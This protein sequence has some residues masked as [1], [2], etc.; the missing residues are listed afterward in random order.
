[1]RCFC[2]AA[3]SKRLAQCS[4]Q[5]PLGARVQFLWLTPI[6]SGAD[7]SAAH[8]A[9]LGMT[10]RGLWSRCSVKILVRQM[11]LYETVPLALSTSSLMLHHAH[12]GKQQ[13]THPPIATEGTRPD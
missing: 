13:V 2:V 10:C 8:P 6:C 3:A 12:I 4:T 7:P 5:H 11:H 9:A 1:M